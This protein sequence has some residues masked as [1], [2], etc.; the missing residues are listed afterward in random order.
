MV[1]TNGIL[2]SSELKEKPNYL[3][4]CSFNVE[5]L[6]ILMDMYTGEDLSTM[7]ETE[8][9]NLTYTQLK[10]KQKPLDKVLGLAKVIKEINSD[11]LMMCEIGG[12]E[13]LTNFNKHFLNSEYIVCFVDGNST[14]GIDLGFLVKKDLGCSLEVVSNKKT[15]LNVKLYSREKPIRFSRNVAELRIR[16]NREI[17]P[18]FIFLLAHLKSQIS[19][20]WDIKG[21]ITREAEV[22]GLVSIYEN[23]KEKFPEA[24]IIIAG[25]FN[26]E[27]TAPEFE[28]LR[29]TELKDIHEIKQSSTEDKASLVYFDVNEV[30]YFYQYDYIF[31]S[32]NVIKQVDWDRSYTYRY[33]SYGVSN[34]LPKTLKDRYL[35]PSDHFPVVLT[36]KTFY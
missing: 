29:S 20:D 9:K 5:N 3:K 36:I 16:F 25:D 28:S 31:V 6:F 23:R 22:N 18:S 19:S 17:D 12:E 26:A 4:V 11:I 8:W 7:S 13:S 24:A 1:S 10:N 21:K 35:Q 33:Q 32:P 15:S 2:N 34:G 30:A 27:L 14:R